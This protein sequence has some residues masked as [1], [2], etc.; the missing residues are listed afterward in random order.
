MNVLNLLNAPKFQSYL[1][2]LFLKYILKEIFGMLSKI[3]KKQQML[4]LQIF[5]FNYTNFW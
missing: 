4:S 1:F 5:E 3:S 2:F